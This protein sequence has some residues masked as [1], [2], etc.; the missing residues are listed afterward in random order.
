MRTVLG[1][2]AEGICTGGGGGVTDSADEIKGEGDSSGIGEEL[3]LGD[4]CAVATDTKMAIRNTRPT[5]V[6]M[7]SEASRCW[8]LVFSENIE[9]F[10]DFARNDKG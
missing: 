10:L 1:G 8:G 4:S 9:R 5:L 2:E 6:V 3:G 7:S